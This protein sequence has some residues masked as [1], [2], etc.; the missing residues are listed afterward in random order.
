MASNRR[1]K[2]IRKVVKVGDYGFLNWDGLKN[3]YKQDINY[4]VFVYDLYFCITKFI[5]II[6]KG[7]LC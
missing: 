6:F 5:K 4:E 7:F 3:I 2:K 1:V